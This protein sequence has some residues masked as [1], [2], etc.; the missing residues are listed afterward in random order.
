MATIPIRCGATAVA[1]GIFK[2]ALQRSIQPTL[3]AENTMNR[4]LEILPTVLNVSQ[5]YYVRGG[6]DRYFFALAE[7]LERH[8]HPV[9]PFASRQSRN[10]PTPWDKYFPAGVDFDRPGAD[11]VLRFI[12]SRPAARS[13]ARLL[14][15]HRPDVAHLHIYYGQLTASILAPLRRA[16]IPIVQTLHDFKIVCP[17]YSLLSHGQICEACQGHQFW[18]ATAKRCNRGSLARSALSSVETYVSHHYGA[19]SAVDQFIAVSNFQRNKL[20]ELGVPA[21]KVTTVHNFADTG[22]ITPETTTGDYLLYFGRIERLKGIMTLA[23]AARRAP[24]LPLVIAGRGEAQDELAAF[25]AEHRLH[26]VKLVGFQQGA[27][28]ERLIRGSIAT[29]CP[30]EGY[31]NCPMA[32]LESYSYAK[33]VIGTQMGGIPELIVD[34]HDGF[35]VDPGDADA[36]ADRL[37]QLYRDRHRAVEMGLAGRLKVETEFNSEVHYQRVSAVYRRAANMPAMVGDEDLSDLIAA[38]PVA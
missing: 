37:D 5:N 38:E 36:L 8:G 14:S 22:E 3:T 26:N 20:V 21:H 9:I 16:G 31:D 11:G 29:L 33:P 13:I 19:V 34:G 2:R 25:V 28:L 12:Y 23:E 24:H 7:L 10:L 15:D 18:R 4:P 17:V 27:D 35:V 30:S 1:S 6:S 32:I